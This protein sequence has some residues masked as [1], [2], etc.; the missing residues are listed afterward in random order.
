VFKVIIFVLPQGLVQTSD[1]SCAKT[2]V[3]LAETM[4]YGHLH[5][6]SFGT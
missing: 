2:N 3:N 1:V 5:Y 4:S 6:I